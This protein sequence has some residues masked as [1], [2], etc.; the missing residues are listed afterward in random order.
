[1]QSTSPMRPKHVAAL[2][3]LFLFCLLGPAQRQHE[4]VRVHKALTA[5][6]HQRLWERRPLAMRKYPGA[7]RKV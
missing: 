3:G 1:M 2:V 7:L 6:P 4:A 5:Q